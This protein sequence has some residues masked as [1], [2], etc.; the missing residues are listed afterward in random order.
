MKVNRLQCLGIIIIYI[1]LEPSCPFPDAQ[2]WEEDNFVWYK[3]PWTREDNYILRLIESIA[4][5]SKSKTLFRDLLHK[6]MIIV[7]DVSQLEENYDIFNECYLSM[8][9]NIHLFIII[10]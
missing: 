1:D 2:P 10:P 4:E 9:L 7:I 3:M 8:S 6:N 5:G